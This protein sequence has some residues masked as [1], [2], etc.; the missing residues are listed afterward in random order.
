MSPDTGQI[1]PRARA[2]AA[3]PA[4][5]RPR[6][7]RAGFAADV[8]DLAGSGLL[9]AGEQWAPHRF[10]IDDHDHPTW[11]FYLQLHGVTRWRADNRTWTVRPGDLLGVAPDTVHAMAEHPGANIHFTYAAFDPARSLERQP[12]LRPLWT[13]PEPVVHLRDAARLVDPFAQLINEVTT[14]QQQLG[15]GLSLALDRIVLEL[16]RRLVRSGPVRTIGCHPAVQEVQHLLDREYAHNWPLRTLAARVGLA[17]N[18]LAAL[19]S[20]ELGRGP[21]EYQ[22]DRK[23]NRA[24]QLLTTSDLTITAIAIEVGFSSGQHLARTFRRSIGL[25]PSEFRA[26]SQSAPG[27]DLP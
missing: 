12:E 23:L 27:S 3:A 10:M 25:S 15:T 20:A 21:H 13:V 24:R 22:T 26:T 1:D 5:T 2:F 14:A 19:F 7:L 16:T 17:P 18:Y 11:E 8:H 4:L 6:Y 9:H